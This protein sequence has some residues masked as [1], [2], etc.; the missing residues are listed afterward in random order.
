[1]EIPQGQSRSSVWHWVLTGPPEEEGKSAE[2]SV[3]AP[4]VWAALCRAATLHCH[5]A[6]QTL[7]HSQK[8]P[9]DVQHASAGSRYKQTGVASI[10]R[11][12]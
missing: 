5:R 10:P 7:K 6:L 3:A 9:D 4:M 8:S 11:L 1:M 2:T 12:Q